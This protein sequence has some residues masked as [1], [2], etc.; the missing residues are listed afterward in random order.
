MCHIGRLPCLEHLRLSDNPVTL[1]PDYRTKVFEQF[2]DRAP[3][4]RLDGRHG[5]QKELDT[6]AVLQALQ[7]AK[8][9][10]PTV[11]MATEDRRRNSQDVAR[12]AS[13]RASS[14]APRSGS[15]VRPSSLV[16]TGPTSSAGGTLD[17]EKME[18]LRSRGGKQWLVEYN[19]MLDQRQQQQQQRQRLD[20]ANH[21]S[22]T[23]QQLTFDRQPSQAEVE[24]EAAEAGQVEA[25]SVQFEIRL[26]QSLARL[27][28]SSVPP[29]LATY[30]PV[31][32]L[33][34]AVEAGDEVGVPLGGAVA[35]TLDGRLLVLVRQEAGELALA[36]NQEAAN[37]AQLVRGY[38]GLYLRLE[39]RFAG[40]EGVVVLLTMSAV[41]TDRLA[42]L[43]S[44]H[45]GLAVVS[46]EGQRQRQ[47]VEY[48][49]QREAGALMKFYAVALFKAAGMRHLVSV[50][51]TRRRLHLLDERM[52]ALPPTLGSPG[53]GDL[54][55]T[56]L[57]AYTRRQLDLPAV[58]ADTVRGDTEADADAAFFLWPLRVRLRPRADGAG[59]MDELRLD[60]N[61]ET[62][63]RAFQEA[64]EAL[65][66]DEEDEEEEE[67]EGPRRKIAER[68]E[69]KERQD[70]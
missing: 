15:V 11:V 67:K 21:E 33:T 16:P 37:L 47:L 30:A 20:E 45:S 12:T 69:G 57:G 29:E 18:S 51:V 61:S 53:N 52:A 44:R 25:G 2:G 50:A 62:D 65:E 10:R 58:E 42:E 22:Q 35:V 28:L 54:N 7:R 31:L 40:P 66:E 19:Q 3:E 9:P 17:R 56:P 43:L 27:L 59:A 39:E 60:F 24:P 6:A 48:T 1:V 64:L 32:P 4:L 63:R 41:V 34:E 14:P 68:K 5:S 55:F 23:V 36:L 49:A 46:L 38:N 8:D 13:P 70:L 26:E